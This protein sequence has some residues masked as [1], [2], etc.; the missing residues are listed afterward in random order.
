[1]WYQGLA[2]DYDGTLATHGSVDEKT[3]SALE[4]FAATK[5]KLLLVTGRELTDLKRVFPQY[6]LFDRVIAENGAL[7][8][9]PLTGCERL[10]CE[11]VPLEF[12]AL[13]REHGIPCSV[14]HAIIASHE[15]HRTKLQELANQAG[16]KFEIQL[17]KGSLMLLPLGVTKATGLKRALEEL[18]LP[19]QRVVGIGDAENDADLL[20]ACGYAVAVA[21]ALPSIKSQAQLVTTGTHGAGVVEL[22]D[23]LLSNDSIGFASGD[24]AGAD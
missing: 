20:H 14:G 21:N 16:L 8:Y 1:M 13:L 24:P 5:R 10:L 3:I 23:N 18:G 11:P 19:P 15:E 9:Q 17:N 12:I 2:T 6:A 22:I 4:R 7:L